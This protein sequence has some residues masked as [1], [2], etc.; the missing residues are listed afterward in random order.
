MHITIKS[1]RVS[2]PVTSLLSLTTWKY[3]SIGNTSVD[4]RWFSIKHNTKYIIQFFQVHVHGIMIPRYVNEGSCSPTRVA[5]DREMAQ[6][7]RPEQHEGALDGKALRQR[8]RAAGDGRG[9]G[10][11]SGDIGRIWGQGN[12]D[13]VV[14]R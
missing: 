5:T 14:S 13:G 7:H 4:T 1:L 6:P 9:G 10:V 11:V 2:M 3:V 12:G 8:E